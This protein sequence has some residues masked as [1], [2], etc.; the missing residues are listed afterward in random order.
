MHETNA[1]PSN[2][3]FDPLLPRQL[4]PVGAMAA[5]AV[6]RSLFGQHMVLSLQRQSQAPIWG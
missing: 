3:W 1:P 4:K 6:A 5:V 2:R